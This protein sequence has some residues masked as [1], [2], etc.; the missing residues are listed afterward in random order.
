MSDLKQ[1]PK[2]I[3]SD[4]KRTAA[5]AKIRQSIRT[6][7]TAVSNLAKAR[8]YKMPHEIE[9][10]TDADLQKQIGEHIAAIE[11]DATLTDDEKKSRRRSWQGVRAAAAKHINQINAV[12][13]EWPQIKWQFYEPANNFVPASSIDEVTKEL[14]TCIVPGEAAAF[15]EKLQAASEAVLELQAAMKENGF[16]LHGLTFLDYYDNPEKMAEAWLRNEE[17][18]KWMKMQQQ[19]SRIIMGDGSRVEDAMQRHQENIKRQRAEAERLRQEFRNRTGATPE[20]QLGCI[21]LNY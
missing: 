14:A 7:Q 10:I 21:P 9:A 13:S 18:Q 12:L 4:E 11:Q 3:I 20:Q 2:S 1:M 17:M 16:M 6:L 8:D 5:D 15:Y 19:P